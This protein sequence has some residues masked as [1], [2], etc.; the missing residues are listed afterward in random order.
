M[1]I[2]EVMESATGDMALNPALG[3]YNFV[4]EH[5]ALAEVEL[6]RQGSLAVQPRDVTV[7]DGSIQR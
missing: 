3:G 7:I 2:E 1:A 6:A 5:V 4:E